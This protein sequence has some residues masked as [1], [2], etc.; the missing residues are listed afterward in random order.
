[1]RK[2]RFLVRSL[3]ALIFAV[4]TVVPWVGYL[5]G[6]VSVILAIDSLVQLKKDKTKKGKVLAIFALIITVI[7][8]VIK[9]S[10]FLTSLFSGFFQ[11]VANFSQ[12]SYE[13]AFEECKKQEEN[14]QVVCY[15]GLFIL[16]ANDTRVTS[17]ETCY[18]IK[19][20]D[21]RT[22]C[23]LFVAGLTNNTEFCKKIEIKDNPQETLD[24]RNQCFAMIT[25]DAIYCEYILNI[26]TKFDCKSE[27]MKKEMEKFIY[28]AYWG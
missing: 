14:R 13:N 2:R 22:T 9:I 24:M 19:F 3:V 27:I 20:D 18:N 16:H 17:G 4:L 1:M 6:L 10:I 25:K 15:I 7:I 5:F 26:T 11:T 12:L 23:Y 28:S 21:A 8:V